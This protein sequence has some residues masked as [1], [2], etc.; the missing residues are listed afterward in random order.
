[1]NDEYIDGVKIQ[2]LP[3]YGKPLSYK[4][5]KQ[6]GSDQYLN[7]SEAEK[8]KLVKIAEILKEKDGVKK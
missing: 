5:R 6:R 3:T 2:R 1:M 8:K 7:V 4:T